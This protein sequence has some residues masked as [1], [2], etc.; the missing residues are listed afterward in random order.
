M[1][2][3]KLEDVKELCK[4]RLKECRLTSED[5]NY[6]DSLNFYGTND[7]YYEECWNLDVSIAAL[8]L[9]RLIHFR[10]SYSGVPS[11]FIKYDEQSNI[12][13]EK[14]AYDKWIEVLNKMIDAFY[15]VAAAVNFSCEIEELKSISKRIDE[16]LKLFAQYY[17]SLWD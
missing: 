14:E 12:I 5:E 2:E 16:G 11:M 4:Y 9:P 17:L 8:I 7:F 13:N 1:K 6:S 3:I 15:L 10:D